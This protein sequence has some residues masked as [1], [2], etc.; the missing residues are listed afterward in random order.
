MRTRSVCLLAILLGTLPTLALAQDGDDRDR[1]GRRAR[2]RG[3]REVSD[4]AGR[5]RR[6]GF[7]LSAGLGVGGETFDARDGLGWSDRVT[8]GVGYIKL[9]GTLNP[10]LLLGVEAQGWSNE[11]YQNDYKRQLGSVMGI[12]QF[13]P[14]RT[15]DFWL[16]GGLGWAWD[17]VLFNSNPPATVTSRRAGTAFAIGLG[18]DARVGRKISLTPTLDFMAQRYDTHDV[19][20]V[21]FG[22]GIT[23][24]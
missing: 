3:L 14:S 8:G 9:G 7:W 24:H 1:D 22:L 21:S 13:Y 17:E 11:S 18:Y 15:G 4:D 5:T 16:R 20:V 19:R 6:Q 12:A 23:F 2:G 10:N